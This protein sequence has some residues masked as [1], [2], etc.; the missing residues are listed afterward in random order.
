[1][2]EHTKNYGL[3]KPAQT[4]FYD[5]DVFNSN[6]DIIDAAIKSTGET[7]QSAVDALALQM[8]N[9][10]DLIS[11]RGQ[12]QTANFRRSVVA[13]CSLDNTEIGLSSYSIGKVVIQQDDG[14]SHVM[15]ANLGVENDYHSDKVYGYIDLISGDPAS[16]AKLCR[17]TY[18]GNLYGGLEFYYSD[19]QAQNVFFT[20]ITN[21]S[22]FGLDFYDHAVNTPIN[23]EVYNSLDYDSVAYMADW[24]HNGD[25]VYHAGNIPAGSTNQAGIV[26]LYNGTDSTSVTVAPTAAAVKSAY[27]LAAAAVP[28]TG[29]TMT[30]RLV[31]SNGGLIVGSASDE[32]GTNAAVQGLDCSAT[33]SC[34][35]ASGSGSVASGSAAS[36]EGYASTASGA[37]SHA[38]GSGTV[39]AGNGATAFGMESVANGFLEIAGGRWNKPSTYS[40]TAWSSAGNAL[41]LGNGTNLATAN[42]FRVTNA[43]AVYALSAFNSTGAD[44]AEYFEWA[45]GNPDGEDRV[46]R[47]VALEEGKIRIADDGERYV[48]GIVSAVP[49]VLGN[50]YEDAWQGMYLTD[51]WGR[52]QYEYAETENGTEYRLAL[53]PDYDAEKT[54]VPRSGRPEWASV[55]LLGQLLVR[56]DEQC[57]V[58]GFC[59]PN[60]HGYATAAE[61]GYP[62]LE[63]RAGIARVLFR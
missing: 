6:A 63:I 25:T 40:S 44:Y 38:G 35:N 51:A 52:P 8:D 45:D 22:I 27:D 31:V 53:N 5:I 54:Y 43:G 55:G 32:L 18:N 9:K 56:C 59:L 21:F 58:G 50:S 29:G 7:A 16:Y 34:A 42:S 60:A 2:A 49:G 28:K 20:G 13:L 19:D 33:G 11:L 15:E 14:E 47:F 46:G 62:I 24:T 39:A 57:R 3:V 41:V 36:A 26:R 4:D 23:T 10:L 30:G 17:F 48:L 12:V 37:Y 1:M 61:S